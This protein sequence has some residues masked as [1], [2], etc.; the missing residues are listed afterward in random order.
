MLRR[1]I[2][3]QHGG[4][5][6]RQQQGI[7]PL[8]RNIDADSDNAA[9]LRPVVPQFSRCGVA[10]RGAAGNAADFIG[11]QI[12]LA[13]VDRMSEQERTNSAAQKLFRKGAQF[14][15]RVVQQLGGAGFLARQE[16]A[17]RLHG[18][19]QRRTSRQSNAQ[20]LLGGGQNFH[21][22][23]MVALIQACGPQ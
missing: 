22:P 10:G 6:A 21:Q 11:Q 2:V 20:L 5:Q 9:A 12:Q 17:L 23:R 14:A 16:D 15:A 3:G 19:H 18:N 4:H 7:A 8:G 13:D 1:V